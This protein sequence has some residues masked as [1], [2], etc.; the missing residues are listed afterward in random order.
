MFTSYV[1]YMTRDVWLTVQLE[2]APKLPQSSAYWNSNYLTTFHWE[3]WHQDTASFFLE[4]YDN[5]EVL[6]QKSCVLQG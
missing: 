2:A 5:R 4:N 1:E 6:E 3:T